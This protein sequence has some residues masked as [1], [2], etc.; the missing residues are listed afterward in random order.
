MHNIVS[1]F[2]AKV[3]FQASDCIFLNNMNQTL[4]QITLISVPQWKIFALTL[5]FVILQVLA[6]A[7]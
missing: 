1:H 7:W 5:L 3:A 4:I 2:S 6:F